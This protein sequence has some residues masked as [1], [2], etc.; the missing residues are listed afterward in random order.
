MYQLRNKLI[1][2]LSFILEVTSSK[3]LPALMSLFEIEVEEDKMHLIKMN[4]QQWNR[5]FLLA[6]GVLRV[7]LDSNKKLIMHMVNCLVLKEQHFI[8]QGDHV[9]S[10]HAKILA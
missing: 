3:D 4:A 2:T 8:D 10:S 1:N 6:V 7:L 9:L 5:I